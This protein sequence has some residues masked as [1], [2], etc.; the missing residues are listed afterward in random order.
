MTNILTQTKMRSLPSSDNLHITFPRASPDYAEL[1]A[2]HSLSDLYGCQFHVKPDCSSIGLCFPASSPAVLWYSHVFAERQPLSNALDQAV[3]A[4]FA[5]RLQDTSST[6]PIP[7]LRP[8][9]NPLVLA[10]STTFLTSTSITQDWPQ[11]L[12]AIRTGQFFVP[13]PKAMLPYQG[14]CPLYSAPAQHLLLHLLSS[15]SD[16][17]SFYELQGKL[18]KQVLWSSCQASIP[19]VPQRLDILSH[20]ASWYEAIPSSPLTWIQVSPL[21]DLLGTFQPFF[22]HLISSLAP[23]QQEKILLSMQAQAAKSA[24]KLLKCYSKKTG[25]FSGASLAQ[26]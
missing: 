2:F 26:F 9:A 1:T 21:M 11:K 25:S 12:W 3:A 24:F 19:C 7:I 15:C 14:T 22:L 23:Q 16:F 17:I 4:I 18:L 6:P 5:H 10:A 8:H 13:V 20:L